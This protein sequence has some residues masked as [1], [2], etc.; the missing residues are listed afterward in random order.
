MT[1][2]PKQFVKATQKELDFIRKNAPK[3]LWK[4][5]QRKT[6]KSRSQVDYQLRLSPEKQDPVIIETTRELFHVVTG[7]V[8]NEK[9]NER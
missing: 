4:M 2:Y 3:G 7:L 5:I 6:R 8:Y 1:E 9:E